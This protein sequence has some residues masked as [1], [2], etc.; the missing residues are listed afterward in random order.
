MQYTCIA[1]YVQ[2][3]HLHFH[4]SFAWDLNGIGIYLKYIMLLLQPHSPSIFFS[5]V[6]RQISLHPRHLRPN[7][8]SSSSSSTPCIIVSN[9]IQPSFRRNGCIHACLQMQMQER[10]VALRWRLPS[11]NCRV[12]FSSKRIEA[13]QIELCQDETKPRRKERRRGGHD[14]GNRHSIKVD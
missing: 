6:T 1:L 8:S 5:V 13:R 7:S 3:I 2:S 14:V 11:Y 10:C 12:L 4:N 9:H